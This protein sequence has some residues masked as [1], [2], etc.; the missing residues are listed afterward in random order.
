MHLLQRNN[1]LNPSH[2]LDKYRCC[3][4]TNLL[5]RETIYDFRNFMLASCNCCRQTCSSLANSAWKN[6]RKKQFIWLNTLKFKCNAKTKIIF[7]LDFYLL[8]LCLSTKLTSS[9][10]NFYML[11][12]KCFFSKKWKI[13]WKCMFSKQNELALESNNVGSTSNCSFFPQR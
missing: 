6:K 12:L 5:L 7:S 11:H 10:A 3:I 9:A 1:H 8:L 4:N 13:I 2:L